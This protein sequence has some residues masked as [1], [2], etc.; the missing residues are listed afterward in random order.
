[1]RVLVVA[2]GAVGSVLGARLGASGHDV[3]LVGR[4]AHVAAIRATGLRIEG[5]EPGTFRVRAVEDLVDAREPDRVLLTAKTF[6]LPSTA[7]ALGSRFPRLPSTLL[8][9]NGLGVEEQVRR[10]LRS[11]GV[12]D[13]GRALVRAVTF[14]GATLER[15][16]TV[17][18]VGD[19]ELVLADPARGDPA[20]DSARDFVELFAPT[21]VRV[22][23]VPDLERELWRK[24]LVNAAINPVTA[25]EGV[26]NGRLLEE[27]YRSRAGRL[28]REAQRAASRAGFEFSDTE[29]DAELERVL[30][31]TAANRSSMLQD[32]E[33]GRPTEVDAISG[34][35]LRVA[36][37][38]GLDLPETRSVVDRLRSRVPS[39][40]D[41]SQPS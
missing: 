10:A 1:V 12:S 16:G 31:A 38:H 2:A 30:R 4:P 22:R 32:V 19:A 8:P 24:A 17:R 37:A 3:E 33:R 34:E 5:V 28:L 6:D 9:Q 36:R 26:T 35:I 41:G 15:P 27:P 21:I 23:V 25:L 7:H 18:Q 14:L 11:T 29:A 13:P 20:S 39:A 40:A